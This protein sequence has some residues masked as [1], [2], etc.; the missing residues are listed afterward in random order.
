M[1]PAE[2]HDEAGHSTERASP[3][4]LLTIQEVADRL[5][6]SKATVYKLCEEGRIPHF[7]VSN[8]IRV[9]AAALE[10]YLAAVS[11]RSKS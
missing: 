5:G 2:A 4:R 9:D 3:K 1:L 8:A 6:V 7:R 11:S 10:A